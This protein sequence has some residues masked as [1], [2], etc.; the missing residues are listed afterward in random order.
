MSPPDPASARS[1]P[2]LVDRLRLLKVWAGNPSYDVIKDRIN[3]G[4]VATGR[5]ASELARRSTVAYCFQPAR[6]RLDTDLVLAV[7]GVLHPDTGYVTQWRQA[8]RVI[9]GELEAAS[10]VRVQDRLP[11]DLAGF[12]GRTG[13]LDR[14]L[15]AARDGPPVVISSIA[16]MAGVGKTELA[17]HFGH[18][19]HREQPFERVLFV[20]LRGFDPDP[21]QPPADPA[22]ILDGFLRLLGLPGQQ[23]PH[24][25]AGRAAT[26]RDR[27]TGT[28]ALVVLDNAATTEQVRP[29]LPA[30]EGCVTL[31]TSRR[32]LTGLHP[33]V[34]L[35][36][37]AFTPGEALA[38]LDRALP[39]SPAARD[40]QA[41]A[42]IARRCGY[43][44]LALGLITRHI[45]GTP[46]WT[47]AE[48]ADRL[49]ERHHDRRL[50][51]GIDL[52][53]TQSYRH[54]PAGRQRLLRLLALHP[55]RDFD[56][57]A[58]A[59]LTGTGV[60]TARS[61]L[62]QLRDDH[63]LQ[64]AGP[65]RYTFHDLV[66]AYATVRAADEEPPRER[67]E[68]LTRLFDLYLA[69]SA[70]AMNV[71][72]P[73]EATVRPRIRPAGTPVPDLTTGGRAR[74][75]LDTERSPLIA[76]AVHTATHGWPAHTVLLSRLLQRHLATGSH[77]A[78]ALTLHDQGFHAAVRLGDVT[79]Q[80]TAL[81]DIGFTYGRLGDHGRAAA[82]L[83]RA[84][85]LFRSAGSPTGQ[86]RAP[87]VPGDPDGR[88][89]QA[90]ILF[91]QM[92]DRLGEAYAREG[93]G[94]VHLE[95]GRTGSAAGHLR[96][97]L[98]LFRQTGDPAGET[99][100]LEGLGLLHTRLGHDRRATGHQEQALAVCRETGDRIG[101]A[102]VLN[103]LGET[104]RRFGRPAEALGHHAAARAI[105]AGTG[106][107]PQQARALTGIGHAHRALGDP[108]LAREHHRQ[109]LA[110]YTGLGRPEAY[111]I[112]A[113][114]SALTGDR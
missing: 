82:A 51:T 10:Q 65:G 32:R 103:S 114:L 87:D 49:D 38:F 39:G 42:R 8:L 70:A 55:G 61:R 1:L 66:R 72:Y 98:T 26:F 71:L 68:A 95:L 86:R 105:A 102:R 57:Y 79:G 34:H 16:G 2:E 77:N 31:V 100:T 91:Q 73:A 43:L 50:D 63:L 5:P 92:D 25:L 19:L 75:W 7:V 69:A 11:A 12:T 56:A 44:P 62:R 78:D 113:H 33:A 84:A 48:H 90:L 53:L 29:L 17:V 6:R 4:W 97:A 15:S 45:R 46:G 54:L 40:A 85:D 107:R 109:A 58:A 108:V 111:Q 52:A 96:R 9:G 112:R 22:A 35:A 37:D 106:D 93:L 76:V 13:E 60:D 41:A 20:N 89:A 81:L 14:L 64:D 3:A 36:V 83:Q 21:S 24:D 27:L 99:W 59:A 18:L 23:I 80:A 101:E 110:I 47:L 28:R 94:L 67:H 104:A 88:S 30:T 74:R